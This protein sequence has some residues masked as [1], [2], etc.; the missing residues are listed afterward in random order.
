MKRSNFLK[1]LSVVMVV[2]MLMLNATSAFAAVSAVQDMTTTK[3]SVEG[4]IEGAPENSSVTLIIVKADATEAEIKAW[5]QTGGA[6]SSDKFVSADSVIVGA[7]GVFK[8]TFT[9]PLTFTAGEYMVIA[10]TTNDGVAFDERTATFLFATTEDKLSALKEVVAQIDPATLAVKLEN[11]KFAL[12]LDTDAWDA[13][14]DTS[15]VTGLQTKAAAAIANNDVIS[16]LRNK[17]VANLTIDDLPAVLDVIDT[18]IYTQSI[19]GGIIDNIDDI[20]DYISADDYVAFAE[21]DKI[22]PEGIAKLEDI[23]IGSGVDSASELEKLY[24]ENLFVIGVTNPKD[25]DGK[26]S[27]EII[28]SLGNDVGL[29]AM[30]NYGHLTSYQQQLVVE[31]CRTSGATTLAALNSAFE[32][33][34]ATYFGIPQT[35]PPPSGGSGSGGGGSV[36]TYVTPTPTPVVTPTPSDKKYSDIE[37]HRWAWDAINALSDRAIFEGYDDGTFRPDDAI[38]REEFIKIA[39]I[40]V[41]GADAIDASAVSS[42]SDAQS[43][44]FAPYVAAAESHGLTG[45]IGDGVFGAGL[46]I[47]RQDMALMLYRMIIDAGI[48]K[49]IVPYAFTD[50]DSIADYAK[51]AVYVLKGMGIINGDPDGSFRPEGSTTRA[52]AAVLLYK[53][54]DALGKIMK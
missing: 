20:K 53:T 45:G 50:A 40:G 33:A 12:G 52:E 39:S 34:V 37:N 25:N 19:A 31:A 47:T 22:S 38:L 28:E 44:W 15:E 4:T 7:N 41:L 32:S 8:H 36:T 2:A 5:E 14:A 49:E 30:T 24:K 18:E 27:R 16:D 17:G 35:T 1:V 43:G 10:S 21:N 26:I 46:Q 48:N 42:F 51:D 9:L 13:I 11:N 6:W 54:L 3:V 29:T 23:V